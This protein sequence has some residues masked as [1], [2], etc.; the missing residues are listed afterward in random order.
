MMG[1]N[2]FESSNSLEPGM[3]AA[4][5]LLRAEGIQC[6]AIAQDASHDSMARI[7]AVQNREAYYAACRL[8]H[9]KIREIGI[10][11]PGAGQPR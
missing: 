1:R 5:D 7:L 4:I 6:D 10:K 3:R 9:G 11:L 2:R 8:L